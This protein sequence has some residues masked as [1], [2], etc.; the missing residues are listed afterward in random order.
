MIKLLLKDLEA[1]KST[2][3]V[4]GYIARV[5]KPEI[6]YWKNVSADNPRHFSNLNGILS[7]EDIEAKDWFTGGHYEDTDYSI[8]A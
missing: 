5:N 4:N 6:K 2:C 1:A 7:S 8:R 3:R